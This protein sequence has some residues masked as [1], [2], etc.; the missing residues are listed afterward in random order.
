MFLSTYE[1][2]IDKKGRVSVPASYRS[3][4]SSLGYNSIICYPSF[5]NQS[6]ESCS[7]DCT[8]LTLTLDRWLESLGIT[9]ISTVTV[10]NIFLTTLK[11]NINPA[12][13]VSFVQSCGSM[14]LSILKLSSY[15]I[16]QSKSGSVLLLNAALKLTIWVAPPLCAVILPRIW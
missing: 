5:N 16:P 7:L 3:H 8:L 13:D 9:C 4:L 11:A 1:N 15:V 6:I 14:Y 2:K 10:P 12:V